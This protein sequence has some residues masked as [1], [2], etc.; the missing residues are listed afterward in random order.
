MDQ[1]KKLYVTIRILAVLVALL[2]VQRQGEHKEATQHSIEGQSANLPKIAISE[3]TS[4]A[5]DRIVIF[6]PAEKEGGMAEDIELVKT[7]ED[8]WSLEKPTKA[9]ANA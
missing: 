3:D 2:F 1:Q 9:K 5:I 7:G 8:A 6:K 4:K